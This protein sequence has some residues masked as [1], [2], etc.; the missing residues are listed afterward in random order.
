MMRLSELDQVVSIDHATK[1]IV[2]GAGISLRDLSEVLHRHGLAMPIL[3]SVDAQSLAGAIATGTHGS[4]LT[5][6]NLASLVRG[7]R[8]VDGRGE[9]VCLEPGDPRLDGARVHLGALGVVTQVRLKVTEA[10]QLE[11]TRRCMPFDEAVARLPEL[12]SEHTF[13]KLWWLPHTDRVWVVTM[14]KTQKPGARSPLAHAV[15][16]ALNTWL[17][18]GLLRLGSQVPSAVP[19]INRLVSTLH[20]TEGTRVAR[21]DHLFTL[22]M[23]PKHRETELAFPVAHAPEA[24]RWVRSWIAEHDARIGFI[25]EMRFVKG[26]EGWLSPAHGQDVCQL[27]VY[28]AWGAD[29]DAYFSDYRAAGQMWGARPHW[30]KELDVTPDDVARWYPRASDFWELARTLDPEGV[31]RNELL[32]RIVPR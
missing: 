27:G 1:E 26:D 15:D 6:G 28:A 21:S 12:A 17:F 4:S 32:D 20:F 9:V 31:F 13:V 11:E 19:A 16:Q 10:F 7:M 29:V 2:V 3:G 5:H 8:L 14:E 24:M 23:P 18:D 30:G 25:V 22:P